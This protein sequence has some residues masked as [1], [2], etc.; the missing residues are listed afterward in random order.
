MKEVKYS[1]S[2]RALLPQSALKHEQQIKHAL[3]IFI[4]VFLLSF[5]LTLSSLLFNTFS[6]YRS[7]TASKNEAETKLSYWE[8]IILSH[9]QFPAAYYEAAV[10]AIQLNKIEKA[11]SFLE[12]ALQV[13]PNF[14]E[15]ETLAKEIEKR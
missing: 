6:E 15:A 11:Q 8:S 3:G 1:R 14:F 5:T 12:K 7:T 9:P 13:D 10:Y 4:C 2:I